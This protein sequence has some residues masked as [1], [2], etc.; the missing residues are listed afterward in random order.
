LPGWETLRGANLRQPD[1]ARNVVK[2]SLEQEYRSQEEY[3]RRAALG[4]TEALFHLAWDYYKGRLVTKDVP[5]AMA[6]LRQLEEK[7]PEWARFNIAKMKYLESDP[8]LKDDIRADCDAGFG[9][10]LYLMA[11]NSFRRGGDIGKSEA[12]GYLLAAAQNGH[13]PS[14]LWAWRLSKLGF[15]RRLATIVPMSWA[16][17]RFLSIGARNLNDVRVAT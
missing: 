2:P 16:A 13:I 12:L 10:A 4:D 9:P 8:S 1:Q 7:S 17:L 15:W 14:K 6:L 3:R 11:A 5:M